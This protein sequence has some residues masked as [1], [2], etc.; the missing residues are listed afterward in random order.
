MQ[1][2][3]AVEMQVQLSASIAHDEMGF[4]LGNNR[5]EGVKWVLKTRGLDCFIPVAIHRIVSRSSSTRDVRD[6]LT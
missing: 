6:V 2:V 4:G 1:A 5:R 3:I